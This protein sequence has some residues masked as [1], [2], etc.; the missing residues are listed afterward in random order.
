LTFGGAPVDCSGLCSEE[1]PL[2]RLRDFFRRGLDGRF[3]PLPRDLAPAVLHADGPDLFEVLAW[4]NRVRH[5]L[6]GDT[7]RLCG[8]ANAK[9][10]RC[11]EDCAYCS[12]ASRYHTDAPSYPM[13]APEDLLALAHAARDQGACAF[14]LVSSGARVAGARDLAILATALAGIRAVGLLPCGSFGAMHREDLLQLRAAGLRR[15]H[16]NLETARS[17]F[18]QVCTTHTYADRLTT[19]RLAR[20]LGFSTCSGGIFGVGESLEQRIELCYELQELAPDSIPL[21][22]LDPRPGTPLAKADHL[23]PRDC[24]RIIALFR[25]AHPGRDILVCGG[26][27][28]NLRQLQ[29]LLFAAG[30]N[31][32]MVGDLLTTAGRPPGADRELVLDLGLRLEERP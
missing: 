31:G 27:E 32:L 2:Q 1:A 29:P 10:G 22:F 18:P 28:R 3:P 6:K 26:R 23:T 12:Q 20:N 8:I 4:S 21:N 9:S 15:V 19:V 24:L 7:V 17:F 16:H 5:E 14:G 11:A 30:A 13:R 25:L